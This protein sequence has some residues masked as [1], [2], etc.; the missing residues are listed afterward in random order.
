MLYETSDWDAIRYEYD[1]V[2]A[3][4]ATWCQ[5]CKQLKPQFARAS[6]LD[7]SRNYYIVD[8]DEVHPDV[9][10]SFYIRSVPK[11]FNVSNGEGI[12]EIGGRTARDIIKQVTGE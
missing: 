11:I 9:V 4:T 2:V 1:A 5:P 12:Q 7:P 10:E 6:V 3:F 8:I